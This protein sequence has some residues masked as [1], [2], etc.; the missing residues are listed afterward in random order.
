MNEPSFDCIPLCLGAMIASVICYYPLE[1][2]MPE[3]LHA[4]SGLTLILSAGVFLAWCG[5]SCVVERRRQ[6][7]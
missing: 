7:V 5:G 3:W 2:V 1:F 6:R 4:L